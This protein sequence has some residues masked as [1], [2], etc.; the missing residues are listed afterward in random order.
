M[1]PALSPQ[2]TLSMRLASALHHIWNSVCMRASGHGT[3]SAIGVGECRSADSPHFNHP[4]LR[5][6]DAP[7]SSALRNVLWND[8]DTRV[9]LA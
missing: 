4:Q 5:Q 1:T 3:R 7:D 2:P 9:S 8:A 6:R